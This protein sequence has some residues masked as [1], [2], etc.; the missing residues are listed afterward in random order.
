MKDFKGFTEC[1]SDSQNFILLK[2]F[3]IIQWNFNYLNEFNNI[4]WNQ[5]NS[6]E[7]KRMKENL[8]ECQEIHYDLVVVNSAIKKT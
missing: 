3:K 7:F 6:E 5:E 2:K 4:Q 8:K 1:E